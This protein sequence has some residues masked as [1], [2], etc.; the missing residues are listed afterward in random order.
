MKISQLIIVVIL[1]GLGVA[2][3]KYSLDQ[4]KIMNLLVT[5]HGGGSLV[6][7]ADATGLRKE[8]SALTLEAATVATQ[9]AE[10]VKTSDSA[11]IEMLDNR[12]KRDDSQSQ[13]ERDNSERDGWKSKVAQAETRVAQIKEEYEKAAAHLKNIP[14]MGD[15][16]ELSAAMENLKSIVQNAKDMQQ[17]LTAD[18]EAKTEV[19]EAATKKVA[20]ETAELEN[21]KA[22]NDRFFSNYNKNKDE[23]PILAV[24]TRW[25]FVVFNAG[26]DSGL[27]AGDTTPILVKR[28][29]NLLAKLRII[30]INGGQVIAEYD[31]TALP[32]GVRLEPGDLAFREK[33]LGS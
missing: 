13:L 7:D 5:T 24:D 31:P 10:A 14:D 27:V 11:R 15:E 23:F 32:A 19:R 4:N 12:N 6:E 3:I 8:K 26:K 33:P 20:A 2:G 17:Q 30:S 29:G 22:I 25:N 1:A 9:R 16:T 18:L 28:G 21:V